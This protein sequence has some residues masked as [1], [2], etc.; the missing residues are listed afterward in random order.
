MPLEL[1]FDSGT[2]PEEITGT[3]GGIVNRADA[4][5][6]TAKALRFL[7]IDDNEET[8]FE[9]SAF[10]TVADDNLTVRYEVS[11]ENNYDFFRILVDGVDVLEPGEPGVSGE[12]DGWQEFTTTLDPGS[13]TIRFLYTKDSSADDG[14]DTAYVS[15][16]S[17]PPTVGVLGTLTSQATGTF[18]LTVRYWQVFLQGYTTGHMEA[19]GNW[20]I[21]EM[22][23]I[24]FRS[25]VGGA[26]IATVGGTTFPPYVEDPLPGHVFAPYEISV[27]GGHGVDKAF[28]GNPATTLRGVNNHFAIGYVF[29]T[30][31]HVAEVA[32][33][34]GS[35]AFNAYDAFSLEWSLDGTRSGNGGFY[36]PVTFEDNV[37]SNLWGQVEWGAFETRT[38]TLDDRDKIFGQ[39]SVSTGTGEDIALQAA[40]GMVMQFHSFDGGWVKAVIIHHQG[41]QTGVRARAVLYAVNNDDYPKPGVLIGASVE[42][43]SVS[44]GYCRYEFDPPVQVP[45]GLLIG[46][47]ADT[48]MRGGHATSTNSGSTFKVAA[49]YG[50]D[51]IADLSG[52][53]T[54]LHGYQLGAYAVYTD[55]EPPADEITGTATNALGALTGSAS[56]TASLAPIT[57]TAAAT[58]GLLASSATGTATAPN[59][60]VQRIPLMGTMRPTKSL[61]ATWVPR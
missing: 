47:H 42:R 38:I 53:T 54:T 5:G 6:G 10:A 3:T 46:L 48:V 52:Q 27:I 4:V 7:D 19:D 43:T 30:A 61:N 35:T 31:V 8:F 18:K 1:T 41:V 16:I 49:S 14:D 22:A 45:S 55:E 12:G 24:E 40:G 11:S 13:H 17:Y 44:G 39:P 37:L 15:L 2:L 34:S 28:D 26:A 57:G 58:L 51:P 23:E 9:L 32:I 29:P 20:L 59:T 50:D 21:S 33:T 25:E 60:F 56:G 36:D